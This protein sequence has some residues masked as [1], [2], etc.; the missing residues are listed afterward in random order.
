MLAEVA[1]GAPCRLR[2]VNVLG[3]RRLVRRG[4]LL[5]GGAARRVQAG[6][7]AQAQR[8]GCRRVRCGCLG[9]RLRSSAPYMHARQSV[10]RLR[11]LASLGRPFS[12]Q[13]N[14]Q[15]SAIPPALRRVLL[16]QHQVAQRLAPAPAR[17]DSPR[18]SAATIPIPSMAHGHGRRAIGG[19]ASLARQTWWPGAHKSVWRRAASR[20]PREAR[21]TNSSSAL[22][23][24]ASNDRCARR[25]PASP[26]HSV[27]RSPLPW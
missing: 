1:S 26:P 10:R 25:C 9:A 27:S 6:R 22:A 2:G 3:R 7:F 13:R 17:R 24:H 14:R 16:V 11:S 12:E 19:S 20:H 8:A 23:I 5:A 21:P 4:L 15:F 18:S